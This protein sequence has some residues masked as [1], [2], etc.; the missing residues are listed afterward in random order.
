MINNIFLFGR[1]VQFIVHTKLYYGQVDRKIWSIF[2]TKKTARKKQK[3]GLAEL[4]WPRW[5]W[6]SCLA[7][8]LT[9]T[10]NFLFLISLRIISANRPLSAHAWAL[11]INHDI[12]ADPRRQKFPKI[13]QN[14]LQDTQMNQHFNAHT[15]T[16]NHNG[17]Q[18][19]KTQDQNSSENCHEIFAAVGISQQVS[20]SDCLSS[21]GFFLSNIVAVSG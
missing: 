20:S 19:W 11:A 15:R 17:Q 1:I 12:G 8:D 5:F 7:I 6:P 16:E 21:E 4:A 3:K 13:R 14:K 18:Q 10:R 9:I 2:R